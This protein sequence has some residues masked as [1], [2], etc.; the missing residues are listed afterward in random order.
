MARRIT[1]GIAGAPTVGALQVSPT[2]ILTSGQDVDLTMS[3]LGTG[4]V[5]IDATT[6]LNE[7]SGLRF[8]DAD[9][10][11]WVSFAAPATIA[12][13]VSWTLPGADGT[14]DQVLTTNGSGTLEWTD[15]SINLNLTESS[16]THYVTSTTETTGSITTL[17]VVNTVSIQASTGTLTFARGSISNSL[18]VGTGP[19][20]TEGEIR[21]T[22]DIIAFVS[23]DRLKTKLGNIEN[24][25]D[26]VDSLNGFYYE[27]N[28]VAQEL[29]YESKRQV[30]VSAQEVQS[31]LPEVVVPAPIDEKYLT[32]KY[33]K[34][35]PLLIEAIKELREEINQLKQR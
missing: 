33:D 30:G 19:S 16:L 12:S 26:K 15:K 13:D 10:S 21:A 3:P 28:D 11:N 5:I 2:A 27:L 1:A 35:V 29:G 24:A 17:D 9:S 22:N 8:A 20:G 34:L 32:V 14:E 23:D 31:I 7:Q 6:Q 25:L 18:G 4:R